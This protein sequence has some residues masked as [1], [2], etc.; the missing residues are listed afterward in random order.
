MVEYAKI[1]VLYHCLFSCRVVV[2]GDRS[3]VLRVCVRAFMRVCARARACVC[4]YSV[5][6]GV[7]LSWCVRTIGVD[8]VCARGYRAL[9]CSRIW[10]KYR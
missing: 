5:T 8:V 6:A 2:Y 3:V 9:L 7:V 4:R 10:P 1:L